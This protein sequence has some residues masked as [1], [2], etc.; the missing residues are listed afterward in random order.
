MQPASSGKKERL[1]CTLTD[2]QQ[3]QALH[4]FHCK[5]GGNCLGDSEV[6]VARAALL[7]LT[8]RGTA[9]RLRPARK[10]GEFAGYGKELRNAPVDEGELPANV[11]NR[12]E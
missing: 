9:P 3:E 6:A 11:R 1:R 10:T 7:Q 2:A 5:F 8:L 4:L 12:C